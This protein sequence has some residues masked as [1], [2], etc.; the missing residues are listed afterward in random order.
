MR[1][2]KYDKSAMLSFVQVLRRSK[3]APSKAFCIN[4]LQAV[5]NLFLTALKVNF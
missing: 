3:L 1:L 5:F 2:H 4:T